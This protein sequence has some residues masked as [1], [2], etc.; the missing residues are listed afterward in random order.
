MPIKG[1]TDRA[2]L[3]RFNRL[4]KIH[5]GGEKGEKGWGEDL[6]YFRFAPEGGP[7]RE[8]VLK[9]AWL[10]CY[11]DQ[12][13]TLIVT[14]P[15]A[16]VDECFPCWQEQWSAS[17]ML[18][19]CDGETMV[20]W[21]R[22]DKRSY[23]R[24]PKPCP[25]AKGTKERTKQ[26]PGCKPQGRLDVFLPQ[27]LKETQFAPATVTLETSSLHDIA[28]ITGVLR[29]MEAECEGDL[30]G[31]A[32]I[33]YRVQKHI[34]TPGQDGKRIRRAKWLVLIDPIQRRGAP[35][36]TEYPEEPIGLPAPPDPDSEPTVVQS[37]GVPTIQMPKRKAIAEPAKH[38]RPTKVAKQAIVAPQNPPEPTT[39]QTQPEAPIPLP[40]P[41]PA[42]QEPQAEPQA[43]PQVDDSHQDGTPIEKRTLNHQAML[44]GK[45]CMTAGITSE[46]LHELIEVCTRY[47]KMFGRDAALGELKD[48]LKMTSRR[49]LTEPEGKRYLRHLTEAL[50]AHEDGGV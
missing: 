21:L 24:D 2:D 8:G 18:H 36:N 3:G 49:F 35:V 14:M 27:L 16:T 34:S 28:S 7:D 19:R 23:S 20:M 13:A 6:S 17:A 11:G 46:T 37:E 31:Q 4:G 41:Q 26:D 15:Y 42:P 32:F 10:K 5:K 43:E 30:T 38:G 40:E 47:D 9:R 48:L 29:K 33:V 50:R 44:F 39:T 25:Y 22:D 1:L 12:P 45:P